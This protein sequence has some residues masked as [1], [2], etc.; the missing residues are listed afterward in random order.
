MTEI[1]ELPEHLRDARGADVPALHAT[2]SL[3]GLPASASRAATS[4]GDMLAH[5][6]EAGPGP[7]ADP[8]GPGRGHPDRR[9]RAP[10][11]RHPRARQFHGRARAALGP[12]LSRRRDGA[13]RRRSGRHSA[14]AAARAA[15][16]RGRS[17]RAHHARADPAPGRPDRSRR[18]ADHRR[19]R[20]AIADVLRLVNFLRR[21]GHPY[22]Q[23]DPANDSCAQTLVERFQVAPEELPI[24]LCPGGQLLRNPTEDQ[25]A[26]C[27][28]L[29]GPVNPDKLY[30]VVDHRRRP[31]RPCHRRSMP[32]PKACR[33]WRSTAA[34]SAARRAPRPG[35]RITSASRPASPAWR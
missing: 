28:G 24:V 31:R 19:R 27:V 11:H 16:R 12:A 34:R 6:G 32:A 5:V 30:D 13:D 15:D 1:S 35:S 10:A 4:A 8:V 22:Q 21:N 3:R 26:R 17:W 9:R 23:L 33:C 7:H 14:R 25:L 29:V 2:R 18:G 20:K